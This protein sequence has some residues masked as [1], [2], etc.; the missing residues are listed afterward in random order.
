MLENQSW[1][2][3][4]TWYPYLLISLVTSSA[5]RNLL[6][7]ALRRILSRSNKTTPV[8]NPS[9]KLLGTNIFRCV[10]LARA[11]VPEC[12]VRVPPPE[13]LQVEPVVR[14]EVLTH[15]Q[16]V[17]TGELGELGV[18]DLDVGVQGQVCQ[19]GINV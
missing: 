5:S 1:S 4:L 6:Y 9:K 15:A 16:H 14:R 19:H 10:H 2:P 7:S 12:G 18:Q 17:L 13:L 3:R 8:L 11:R